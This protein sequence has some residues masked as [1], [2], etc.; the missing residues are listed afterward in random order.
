[1]TDQKELFPG[2]KPRRDWTMTEAL[3]VF[4]WF[5]AEAERQGMTG[6]DA[7][8]WAWRK[9]WEKVEAPREQFHE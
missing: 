7:R 9:T 3:G 6:K 1:M 8:D 4:E 2:R 5:F